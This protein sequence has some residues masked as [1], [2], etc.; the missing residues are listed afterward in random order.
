MFPGEEDGRT[1]RSRA[2]RVFNRSRPSFEVLRAFPAVMAVT[3]PGR[4]NATQWIGGCLLKDV[5]IDKLA[6]LLIRYSTRLTG[7]QKIFIEAFD[8]PADLVVALVREAREVGGLPVVVIKDNRV[9]R[10]Q[11]RWADEESMALAG[12]LEKAWME[13]MDAYIGVR[14]ADNISEL[15]D[16][17]QAKMNLYQK[18]WWGPVHLEQRINHTK[19]VVLR[20][21]T[22]SMAQQANMSTEAFE[23]FYFDVCANLDYPRMS[24]AMDPLKRRMEATDKVRLT[25]PGTDLTFSIK[26]IPAIK[27]DGH[28][29]IPD[30]EVYT[31]PV[32]DSVNG[33]ISYN[34][35][36]IYQGVTFDNVRLEFK[37][38][39]V[40]KASASNSGRLNEILDT[41]EGA[42]YV[43]EFAIG[44][45]PYIKKPMKDILF[46][47]KIAGSI[48][49]TPGN[50][51]E[52]A[53]NGNRSQVHW[54]LV[55]LQ[56]PEHGGGEIWFDGELIRKDGRFVVE[57]LEGLNPERL[58]E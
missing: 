3:A 57:D 28:R 4:L 15:C 45:N 22:P 29:N 7:G 26:G 34:A 41:D 24:E 9:L 51:Y 5:R 50:A 21:P 19:W 10:E 38:G 42:R 55:L 23:D 14:G 35:A 40:V 18:L 37:N 1:G 52:I 8:I 33:V 2:R 25:S 27:C 39:K 12:D 54:D 11:Y 47:E 49:F 6:R 17:P 30:G 53:D 43:G 56:A 58:L 20:Y 44:F 16:V 36:T 46:D 48:H 13:R 32:R 31:S